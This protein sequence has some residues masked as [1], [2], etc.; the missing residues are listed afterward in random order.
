MKEYTERDLT[1]ILTLFEKKYTLKLFLYT[2]YV[3]STYKKD[4]NQFGFKFDFQN[5]I[6]LNNFQLNH[7]TVKPKNI[8][9]CYYIL[10]GKSGLLSF[11]SINELLIEDKYIVK[12]PSTLLLYTDG[13]KL[14]H[15]GMFNNPSKFFSHDLGHMFFSY[16]NVKNIDF[17]KLY[18][19]Y[20][21]QPRDN[22][23]LH[24]RIVNIFIWVIIFESDNYISSRDIVNDILSFNTLEFRKKFFKLFSQVTDIYDNEYV[25]KYLIDSI[26]II[27]IISTKSKNYR[28]LIDM[29]LLKELEM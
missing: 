4:V 23:S 1:Q 8:F 28:E 13:L 9:F 19:F 12:Y 15:V 24:K 5:L 20:E 7:F 21:L 2:M 25:F 29:I 17:T 3:L 16:D 11:K 18:D 26:D 6:L 14:P 22:N 27:E 10:I